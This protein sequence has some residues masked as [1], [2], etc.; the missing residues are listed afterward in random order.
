MFLNKNISSIFHYTIV[1]CLGI[2]ILEILCLKY[3]PEFETLLYKGESSSIMNHSPLKKSQTSDQR[4]KTAP[5]IRKYLRMIFS[6]QYIHIHE[7]YLGPNNTFVFAC[8]QFLIILLIVY[9]IVSFYWADIRE[10]ISF[11]YFFKY[12]QSIQK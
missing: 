2:F 10:R 3:L 12:I 7:L 4:R 8:S 9:G 11:F 6:F 5:E 1:V